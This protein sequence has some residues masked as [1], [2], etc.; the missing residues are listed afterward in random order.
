MDTEARENHRWNMDYENFMDIDIGDAENETIH[1]MWHGEK[2]NRVRAL[3]A[4]PDGFKD[5]KPCVNCFYPRKTEADEEAVINGRTV[6][7]ENYINR[8]QVVGQ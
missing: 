5:L 7:V 3:H 1:E 2:F 6:K 4:K 8:A